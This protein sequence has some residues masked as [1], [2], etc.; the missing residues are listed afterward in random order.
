MSTDDKLT[1]RETVKLHLSRYDVTSNITVVVSFCMDIDK[2]KRV[3]P[4][5]QQRHTAAAWQM[6]E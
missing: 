6:D 3:Q 5:D 4:A 1:A 2:S